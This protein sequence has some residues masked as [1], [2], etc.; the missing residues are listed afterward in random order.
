MWI[1]NIELTTMVLVNKMLAILTL[2]LL[3]MVIWSLNLHE[4]QELHYVPKIT[5]LLDFRIFFIVFRT[6]ARPKWKIRLRRNRRRLMEVSV[7]AVARILKKIWYILYWTS[8]ILSKPIK[9]STR[10][11]QNEILSLYMYGFKTRFLR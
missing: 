6:M 3:F 4:K 9:M 8:V 7:A 2:V 11:K 5:I 1:H 10:H